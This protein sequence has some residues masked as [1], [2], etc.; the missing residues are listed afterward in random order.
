MTGT[1]LQQRIPR[2]AVS[3][4]FAVLLVTSALLLIF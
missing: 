1:A 3:A 2:R 4:I